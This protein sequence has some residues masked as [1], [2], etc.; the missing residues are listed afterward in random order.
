MPVKLADLRGDSWRSIAKAIQEGEHPD[1]ADLITALRRGEPDIPAEAQHYIAD[2]LA[3]EIKRTPGRKP[4]R[5]AGKARAAVR[6][7]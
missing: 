6:S 5:M 2:M 3:G 7:A 1:Q 4:G